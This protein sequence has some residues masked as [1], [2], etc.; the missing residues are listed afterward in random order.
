M[1]ILRF[2]TFKWK[3]RLFNQGKGLNGVFSRS[4][5]RTNTLC[6]YWSSSVSLV[7]RETLPKHEKVSKIFLKNGL[8]ILLLLHDSLKMHRNS[9]NWSAFDR[10][11]KK[12]FINSVSLK[13]ER[14]WYKL[15]V[16]QNSF[17]L[18]S[19]LNTHFTSKRLSR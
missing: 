15:L 7:V 2:L 9:K 11:K 17:T 8:K 5:T 1:F 12:L 19:L 6:W 4:K 14:L 10:R 3:S 16:C 18:S 13:L